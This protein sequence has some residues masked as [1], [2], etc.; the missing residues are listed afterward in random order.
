MIGLLK[1]EPGWLQILEQEGIA[2]NLLPQIP[3]KYA[4]P[5]IIN[6]ALNKDEVV[7]II[8][9]LNAG[10]G[11]ITDFLNL[12]KIIPDIRYK[13][14]LL[15]FIYG[16]SDLFNNI[17][18]LDLKLKGNRLIA[19]PIS[20]NKSKII[21]ETA[22]SN[23]YIIALP[24]DVNR[25]ILDT[26]SVLKPFY[27]PH[28]KFPYEHVA[29]I[30][31]GA[32]RKLVINCLRKLYQKMNLSYSHLWYYPNLYQT[33]FCFRVDTDFASESALKTTLEL[34]QTKD[35]NFTYFINTGHLPNIQHPKFCDIQIHCLHHQ[36]FRDYL[37]NYENIKTAKTILENNGIKPIGFVSPFGMWNKHLQWAM[38]SSDIK[39]SSE[40]SLDYDNLPFYP[41]VDN[42]KSSVLQIPVHPICLGQLLQADLSVEQCKRYYEDYIA[43]QYRSNE[44]IFIYDHP[45]RIHQFSELFG[46]ILDKARLLDNVEITTM[47]NFY[48][49]WVK[50]L[51]TYNSSRWHIENNTL[52]IESENASNNVFLHIITPDAKETY[53]PLKK[54]QYELTKLQYKPLKPPYRPKDADKILYARSFQAKIQTIFYET[55]KR[56]S[57]I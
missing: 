42:K 46:Q 15:H 9:L 45:H 25:A 3:E 49:W 41:I 14:S 32:V 26:R 5:I 11:I 29:L 57:K 54:G 12:K 24:F 22:Y 37:R 2:Y 30:N 36:V 16:E 6:R 31:K 47:T 53:I 51:N 18:I 34:S 28:R 40:F 8:N 7:Y 17:P 48:Y 33:C 38:E 55:I 1:N 44:P 27:F 4:S 10:V 39:Y 35:I 56:L 13:T 19:R 52:K 43:T 50:R 23:G 20:K 21:F